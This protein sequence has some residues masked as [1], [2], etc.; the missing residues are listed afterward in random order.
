MSTQFYQHR[1]V[2]GSLSSY[3]YL[4][5]RICGEDLNFRMKD[6][7]VKLLQ[8]ISRPVCL[9]VRLLSGA[10]DQYFFCLTIVGS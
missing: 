5:I 7:E 1:R 3:V 8:I 10:H 2:I 4:F 6:V 9:G